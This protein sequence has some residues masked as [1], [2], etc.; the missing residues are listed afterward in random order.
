MLKILT[1]S[2]RVKIVDSYRDLLIA[3]NDFPVSVP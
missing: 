2:R 1:L 3:S